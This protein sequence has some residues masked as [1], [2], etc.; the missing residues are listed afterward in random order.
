MTQLA[1]S[2]N[3]T[4]DKAVTVATE[5]QKTVSEASKGMIKRYSVLS[6]E[7]ETDQQWKAVLDVEFAEYKTPGLSPEGRRKIVIALFLADYEA[8]NVGTG[9][10]PVK[11]VQDIL[12]S[13]RVVCQKHLAWAN[14][15]VSGQFERLQDLT[16]T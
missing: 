15:V 8:F 9:Q 5:S 7:Q 3:G 2:R 12:G 1:V 14:C 10:L 11:A 6:C 4:S 13:S 16:G